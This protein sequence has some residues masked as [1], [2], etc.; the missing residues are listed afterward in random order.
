MTNVSKLVKELRDG[1]EGTLPSPWE[2]GRSSGGGEFLVYSDDNLGTA[3]CQ[4]D[5]DFNS[6]SAGT[7]RVNLDH[8]ARC[9]PDNIRALLD[10]HD[11]LV[12]K[13]EKLR[14]LIVKWAPLDA[15]DID[16][17]WCPEC[18]GAINCATNDERCPNCG[19]YLA[20]CQPSYEWVKEIKQTIGTL[21][22]KA[23]KGEDQ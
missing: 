13:N 18:Q 23:T 2:R 15:N 20:D 17:W 12:E 9:S 19:T 14:S 22:I 21:P 16:D 3:V 5:S 8:I 1:L 11:A 4:M 7:R 6:A 10:S